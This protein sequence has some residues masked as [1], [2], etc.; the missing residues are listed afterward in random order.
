VDVA[1]PVFGFS[2]GKE[3]TRLGL[4]AKML[5]QELKMD[6]VEVMNFFF[7]LGSLELGVVSL[8]LLSPTN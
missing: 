1:A 2:R 4:R 7:Q 3:S 8:V 6:L 5:P